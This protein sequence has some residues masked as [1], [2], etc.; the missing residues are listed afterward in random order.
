[1][2]Q[3]RPCGADAAADPALD[4]RPPEIGGEERRMHVRAYNFWVSLLGGRAYPSIADLDPA[5]AADFGPN[6]VLLDFTAPGEPAIA[7]LGERLRDEC[8]LG[9]VRTIADVPQR[10]LLGRLTR[11]YRDIL[12]NRAP[13]GFE[14]EFAD[15][16]EATTLYR[17][18]LMPFSS[19]GERIDFVYGVINW[20]ALANPLEVARFAAAARAALTPQA[21]TPPQ[22]AGAPVWADGPS[23][24]NGAGHGPVG[25]TLAG[26]IATAR[27]GARRAEEAETDARV[28]LH[29]ALGLAYDLLIEAEAQPADFA[30]HVTQRDQRSFPHAIVA[31]T[32]GDTVDPERAGE[33]ADALA[34]ARRRGV[35][36]GGFA[37]YA[38]EMRGGIRAMIVAER[39][40]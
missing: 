8:G 10:T 21:T 11:R 9:A 40:V 22:A 14:A 5:R 20:K 7:Y 15:R 36:A 26:R 34:H 24:D 3:L 17:G 27:D 31:L 32:F 1:M 25:A 19:D 37:S 18:I 23:G 4:E 38:G 2:D 12:A 29:E 30:A 16:G 28:A 35:P 13:I 6:A 33:L 39:A